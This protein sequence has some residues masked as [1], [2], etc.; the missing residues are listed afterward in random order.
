MSGASRLMKLRISL[1]SEVSFHVEKLKTLYCITFM[2]PS[3]ASARTLSGVYMRIGTK[4]IM[5]PAMGISAMV[6]LTQSQK[7][8]N[9]RFRSRKTGKTSPTLASNG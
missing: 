6:F 1:G 7:A 8:R 5:S 9:P 4:P 2:E 3:G